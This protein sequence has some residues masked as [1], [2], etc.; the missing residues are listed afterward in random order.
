ME[1]ESGRSEPY[2]INRVGADIA[3]AENDPA[4]AITALEEMLRQGV[5]PGGLKDI[6]R[7]ESLAIAYEM[8][9][10]L[11][12]AA[13]TLEQ[14]VGVYGGHTLARYELGRVLQKMGRSREAGREFERFLGAW[15]QADQG[16]AQVADARSRLNT[17][18][19]SP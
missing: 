19:N 13:E 10:R 7:R 5:P 14:L 1:K 2:F 15:T 9:D 16:L 8:N 11:D 6:E 12:E 3:I 4:T 18:R 17:V